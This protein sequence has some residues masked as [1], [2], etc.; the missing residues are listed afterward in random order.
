MKGTNQRSR[1]DLEVHGAAAA[2]LLPLFRLQEVLDM[3]DR[4]AS[5]GRRGDV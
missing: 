1:F 2:S 3:I 5:Q 4:R